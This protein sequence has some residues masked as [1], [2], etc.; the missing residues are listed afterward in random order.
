MG[1]SVFIPINVNQG[2][3][4]A[5][6]GHAKEEKLESP[7]MTMSNVIENYLA[8]QASSG[9]TAP[10]VSPWVMSTLYVRQITIAS[11]ETSAG[12][13]ILTKVIP[14]SR[15][16]FVLGST[17]LQIM[18][19]STGTKRNTPTPI[20]KPPSSPTAALAFPASPTKTPKS[21]TKPYAF[22]SIL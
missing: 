3:V 16:G 14:H 11:Q 21:W 2:S 12:T 7:A 10:C 20:Q 8:D 15:Q 17:F 6:L 22:P 1:V 9:H 18:R 19:D 13:N 5:K 4:I